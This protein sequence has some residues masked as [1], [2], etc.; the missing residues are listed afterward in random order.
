MT[1]KLYDRDS[2]T[3]QFIGT[4][5]ACEAKGKHYEI[6]L[7]QTAFFPG[8]GGQE[9]DSGRLGETPVRALREE[10]GNIYHEL[11]LPFPVGSELAGE[12]DWEA[13]FARMQNHS[14]EHIISG[15]VNAWFG[16][17]NVGFH[18]SEQEMT[19]D[20]DGEFTDE[21]IGRIEIE[22]NRIVTSNVAVNVA[23]PNA[24]ELE[25]LEYRS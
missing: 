15:R 7:D 3:S 6:L 2:H 24:E 12:I 4:V 1:I 10:N 9:A 23:Y 13:R 11:D 20:F 5:L 22:A 14:G 17:H 19:L 16:Y 8:G 21:E 25:R 18:M